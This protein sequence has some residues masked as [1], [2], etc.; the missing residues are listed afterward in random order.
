MRYHKVNSLEGVE[1]FDP[2]QLT[3]SQFSYASSILAIISM[4]LAKLSVL[5]LQR[6]LCGTHT[7]SRYIKVMY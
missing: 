3:P 4:A 5:Q 1:P 2:R 7:A 6:R